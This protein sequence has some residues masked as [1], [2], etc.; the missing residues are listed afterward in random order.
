MPVF[1][2]RVLPI[3]GHARDGVI[4]GFMMHARKMTSRTPI[5][6]AISIRKGTFRCNSVLSYVQ[7]C[8]WT[9]F[10]G[11]EDKKEKR[12]GNN[13]CGEDYI[14][15]WSTSGKTAFLPLGSLPELCVTFFAPVTVPSRS[16]RSTHP[17]IHFVYMTGRN[18]N[19]RRIY[20][21]I[22]VWQLRECQLITINV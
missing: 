11:S 7:S 6:L 4:S 20:A 2:R 17:L 22:L 9:C 19:E 14:A 5:P 18:K 15:E 10:E 1:R 8:R 13:F 12:A 16:F 3:P 21:S